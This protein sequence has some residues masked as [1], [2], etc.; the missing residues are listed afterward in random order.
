MNDLTQAEIPRLDD[1]QKIGC[2]CGIVVDFSHQPSI[3]PAA[4]P[5]IGGLA[6]EL[7]TMTYIEP[8]AP[9]AEGIPHGVYTTDEVTHALHRL[10]IHDLALEG[11]EH[12]PP[13][14]GSTLH[15]CASLRFPAFE[16]GLDAD[17]RRPDP[18]F[19]SAI[20]A[21]LENSGAAAFPALAAVL[22]RFGHFVP[23]RVELGG[24]RKRC[25]T[26]VLTASETPAA[27]TAAAVTAVSSAY[28]PAA[29]AGAT[30]PLR[31]RGLIPTIELLAAPLRTRCVE[32]LTAY[33]ASVSFPA[34][35][36]DKA[37]FLLFKAYGVLA[38]LCL[39][40]VWAR[41]SFV[42]QNQEPR[43]GQAQ[44]VAYQVREAA[45]AD[46]GTLVAATVDDWS[47]QRWSMTPDGRVVSAR[48]AHGQEFALTVV[49]GP[50]EPTVALAPLGAAIGQTWD[51]DPNGEL[52][53]RSFGRR[54]VLVAIP[55]NFGGP[56]KIGVLPSGSPGARW[57]MVLSPALAK[58][59]PETEA[60]PDPARAC[61]IPKVEDVQF[62][63]AARNTTH[64]ESPLVLTLGHGER[65]ARARAANQVVAA[66][67]AGLRHQLWTWTSADELVSACR[68]PEDAEL[69]LTLVRGPIADIVEAR[70][71]GTGA[72]PLS[73]RW[74][75][76]STGALLSGVDSEARLVVPTKPGA[77]VTVNLTKSGHLWEPLVDTTAVSP[78]TVALETN[79]RVDLRP[80]KVT[81]TLRGVHLSWL[82]NG[83]QR[84][85]KLVTLEE[86]LDGTLRQN[87][88]RGGDPAPTEIGTFSAIDPSMVQLRG[89]GAVKGL[90]LDV[91]N[92]T[93]AISVRFEFDDDNS[94][95]Q[96]DRKG[97][98]CNAFAVADDTPQFDQEL[99]ALSLQSTC[100]VWS[101]AQFCVRR[102]ALPDR[103]VIK[104]VNSTDVLAL[105]LVD[106]DLCCTLEPYSGEARQHWFLTEA[107]RLVNGLLPRSQ[108]LIVESSR[109]TLTRRYHAHLPDRWDGV[110]EGKDVTWTRWH[111]SPAD[112]S[113]TLV[114][115]PADALVVQEK[116]PV[117][118]PLAGARDARWELVPVM[119]RDRQRVTELWKAAETHRDKGEFTAA[120]A[121]HE[122]AL[123]LA[124][125]LHLRDPNN[126]GLRTDLS[127]VLVALGE[128]TGAF[129]RF[130]RVFV[131]TAGAAT[132]AEAVLVRHKALALFE[133]ACALRA[134]EPG[135]SGSDA[136]VACAVALLRRGD[137]LRS[138][139]R[140]TEA[141]RDHAA[142]LAR[143]EAALAVN[144]E[145][146]WARAERANVM[147][148]R[149]DLAAEQGQ[150]KLALEAYREAS[151]ER[152]LSE[153]SAYAA[154]ISER[155]AL[156]ETLE[157]VGEAF[158][159]QGELAEAGAAFERA[160]SIL[161]KLDPAAATAAAAAPIEKPISEHRHWLIAHHTADLALAEKQGRLADV[162]Q[163]RVRLAS[164]LA[165]AGR[166][167]ET[168]EAYGRAISALT[169]AEILADPSLSVTRRFA[170]LRFEQAIFTRKLRPTFAE[171][172]RIQG[173]AL[174]AAKH[175][176]LPLPPALSVLD[177]R[178]PAPLRLGSIMRQGQFITSPGDRYAL[179]LATDGSLGIV[180]LA[181]DKVVANTARPSTNNEALRITQSGLV[182]TTEW[183]T[184]VGVVHAGP[185]KD[186]ELSIG[187]DGHAR[188][189]ERGSVVWYSH[190]PRERLRF[191]PRSTERISESRLYP[192]DDIRSPSG[193]WALSMRD[194]G[195]VLLGPSVALWI[196]RDITCS[197]FELDADG[198]LHGIT[199]S[200]QAESIA[201]AQLHGG[202]R[203]DEAGSDPAAELTVSDDGNLTICQ[204]AKRW[205]WNPGDQALNVTHRQSILWCRDPA[206]LAN[207]A[208]L[209]GPMLNSQQGSPYS[210][211]F[212]AT[213]VCLRYEGAVCAMV[214]RGRGESV[215]LRKLETD[216]IFSYL[217]KTEEGA[218][219]WS[220]ESMADDWVLQARR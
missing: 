7:A 204:G 32:V 219:E 94:W 199:M 177:A 98:P 60:P 84:F 4:L 78:S 67:A 114:E 39:N 83:D 27:V 79:R 182:F 72:S 130:G 35:M 17:H 179:A 58:T 184:E 154:T 2:F 193:A 80:L 140:D 143:I 24:E 201:K 82:G 66:P 74:T 90:K 213:D 109:D 62:Q 124:D 37:H 112:Q 22:A 115:R 28:F 100:G 51:L 12:G 157:R 205:T 181:S 194:G 97:L 165:G 106:R 81:G 122:Q 211:S 31:H 38:G 145:H 57:T 86:D 207:L 29:L 105:T 95:R 108:A 196:V 87:F 18:A 142:G 93:L 135:V 123:G 189:S 30:R 76:D 217:R 203:A 167:Q 14:T 49:G 61:Q 15:V 209:A 46:G 11:P 54:L 119:L 170:D 139:G 110:V 163:G 176:P 116:K 33:A 102:A 59:P 63:I 151:V 148:R 210:V 183:G 206:H 173:V 198:H 208:T 47:D 107:G 23:T 162:W 147:V 152:S 185:G 44:A 85:L 197:R 188:L 13:A 136:Q 214:V 6:A 216:Q 55:D 169:M 187:D 3:R 96:S 41:R 71:R 99:L 117:I 104:N 69:L 153:L 52:V 8:L 215:R 150:G 75:H 43:F 5:V 155:R 186:L 156:V 56:S 168:T 19:V 88:G 178:I 164:A 161:S 92:G 127:R 126:E 131:Q 20:A 134:P 65:G 36:A 191:D 190:V 141:A 10:G 174:R 166:T 91:T 70:P 192:G 144:S 34:I 133:R 21:A 1:A 48:K 175:D 16:L 111:A 25:I 218:S 149:G 118:A 129:D 220:R 158:Q 45:P 160:L 125:D 101:L 128:L 68:G 137:A 113:L 50:A 77:P 73:Q 195:L 146:A 40:G 26:H 89:G 200:G 138:L 180:D 132:V 202:G 103:F 53:N 42:I 120:L 9:V 121:I 159:T 64:D 212:E 172:L 171:G